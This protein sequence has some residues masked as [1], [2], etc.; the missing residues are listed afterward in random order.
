MI[1]KMKFVNITGPRGDIDRVMDLYLSRYEI[2]LESA[3]SE[4]KT[5]DN[6]RPFVEINPYKEA[7]DKA[8]QFVGYLEDPGAV[9]PST[10]LGLDDM[11]E[12]LRNANHQYMDYQKQT[13]QLKNEQ[14]TLR[15]KIR[16][17]EPFRALDCNLHATLQFRY[18]QYRFGRISLESHHRL[19]RYL[20]EDLDAVFVESTRD[21]SYV[22]GAY[23]VSSGEAQKVDAVFRSLH[24]E[25]IQLP[26]EFE[27]TPDEACHQLKKQVASLQEQIDSI[28]QSLRTMLTDQAP[29][30]VASRNRLEE[31]AT[32]FDVR[33]LAARVDDNKEDYY[34]LCGW[35]AEDDVDKFLQEIKED[36]KVF[37][38]VEEDRDNYFGEPPT[39]LENPKLFKPFEMFISMY[40]LPAHNEMDPTIFVA[41]T[42]SFIFGVMFGDVGQGLCLVMGGGLLYHFKKIALAGIISTAGIFSTIFGVLFGSFFGFEDV[43]PALWLQ[44]IK[45]MTTLPFLGKLNTIFIVAVAFGMLVIIVSIVLNIVNAF[46]AHDSEAAWFDANGIAGLVFYASVVAVIVLFMT[47]HKTPAGFVLAIM[48]GVPLLLILLKEPLMRKIQKRSDKMEE[49]TGM[50]LVQG[51]FELFE[52]LLSYFSNTLSFVRIGAF[53]VSHAAMMEVVL[54]LAGAESGSPNWVIVVLGNIFVCGM[55][56]LVVGIQVLRLEYYEMFSR[57][58]KGSGREFKPYKTI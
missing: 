30:L 11:F 25:R 36:D 50:Y 28:T 53:A 37:V 33:K 32:N 49:S 22:Y 7:L 4:L 24:F 16:L 34:I 45:H 5:V 2:Q 52:M 6:L 48:F 35:M 38:V 10:E 43:I 21:D 46:R 47:G 54:M 31:L 3:L 55:E 8:R 17:L 57:F 58:Y 12:L 29:D 26:D 56:G 19:E 13:D 14:E 40:G 44:P 51:F 20:M 27:C 42:Y 41:L 15:D 18:I 9:T 23:F 1:V 39:K